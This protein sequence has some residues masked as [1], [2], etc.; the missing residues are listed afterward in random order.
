V[1]ENDPQACPHDAP[2][3]PPD[4]SEVNPDELD[5]VLAEVDAILSG[6]G[7]GDDVY[8][9]AGWRRESMGA[10]MSGG[11][12]V[13]RFR[14]RRGAREKRQTYIEKGYV[15]LADLSAEEQQRHERNRAKYT[16]HSARAV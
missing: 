11:Q 5:G 2:M 14:W 6:D 9:D 10:R 12:M 16:T 3:M 1:V 13:K 8:A 4:L 15:T 7:W